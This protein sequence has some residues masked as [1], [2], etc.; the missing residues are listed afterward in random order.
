MTYELSKELK[1]IMEELA[2]DHMRK[3]KGKGW[4]SLNS[5]VAGFMAGVD[6][7]DIKTNRFKD[8]YSQSITNEFETC[9]MATIKNGDPN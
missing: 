9:E 2:L 8:S 6:V 1:A 7:M 5:F 3:Y 4:A